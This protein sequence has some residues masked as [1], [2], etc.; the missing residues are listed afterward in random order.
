MLTVDLSYNWLTD[1]TM[2][3]QK[4]A[5]SLLYLC[6][7]FELALASDVSVCPIK[8][9]HL[10]ITPYHVSNIPFIIR[11]MLDVLLVFCNLHIFF[12]GSSIYL[13]NL[14]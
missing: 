12:N 13:N 14:N 3:K 9:S 4:M 11:W 10:R 6:T 5:Y 2:L 1:A 7:L 8:G